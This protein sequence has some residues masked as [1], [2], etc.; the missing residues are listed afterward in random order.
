M[1]KQRLSFH[2][3]YTWILTRVQGSL[4]PPLVRRAP[5]GWWKLALKLQWPKMYLRMEGSPGFSQ[6]YLICQI[7]MIVWWGWGI[8]LYSSF[9]LHP[10]ILNSSGNVWDDGRQTV[11]GKSHFNTSF[12]RKGIHAGQ[13][14]MRK[15]NTAQSLLGIHFGDFFREKLIYTL[16]HPSHEAILFA[17]LRWSTVDLLKGKKRERYLILCLDHLT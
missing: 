7:W 1:G 4:L 10:E 2:F 9:S 3:I 14:L 11:K 17:I 13:S 6:I 12:P 16:I 8:L 5:L 15:T